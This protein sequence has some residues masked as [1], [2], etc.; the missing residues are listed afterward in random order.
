[1]NMR[2]LGGWAAL[3]L[4]V[5]ALSTPP[6]RAQGPAARA[7]EAKASEESAASPSTVPA[8]T[9]VTLQ[10]M[11]AVSTR[12]SKKG[13]KIRL[14]VYNAVVLNGKTLIAQDAPATGE[15]TS[16]RGPSRFGRRGQL[17]IK[18]DHV[19]AVDGTRI[20]LEPYK[21]GERFTVQGGAASTAGA[22][23]LGPVGLIGGAFIKGRHVTVD[24]GTRV[25]VKVSGK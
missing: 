13:D 17:K 6:V 18:V 21:S 11:E 15:V 8:G 19:Q 23:L 20:P 2:I 1:M 24:E 9:P 4:A 16:V 12:H 25:I 10:L 7:P 5:I 3:G 22:I 14:R